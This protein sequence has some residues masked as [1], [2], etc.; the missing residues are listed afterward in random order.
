MNETEIQK[1]YKKAKEEGRQ[2][3]CP[4]CKAPLQIGQ[5]RVGLSYWRWNDK[6]KTFEKGN[7]EEGRDDPF[8]MSCGAAD[9]DFINELINFWK[10]ETLGA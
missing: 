4:H 9:W 10:W 6:K 3:L 7:A 2:P 8:C 5:T 1:E